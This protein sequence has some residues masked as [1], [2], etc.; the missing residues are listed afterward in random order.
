MATASFPS[1]L[2][3]QE[4]KESWRLRLEAAQVDYQAV[5][6]RYRTLLQ[7]VPDGMPSEHAETVALVREA[8][9]RALAEYQRVLQIFTDLTV[10]AIMPEEPW[11][12]ESSDGIWQL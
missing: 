3:R 7:D 5:S 4:L 8:E 9:S 10:K 11:P 2:T 1:P 12:N 6:Q